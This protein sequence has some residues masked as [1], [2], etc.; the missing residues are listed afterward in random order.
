MGVAGRRGVL[1]GLIMLLGLALRLIY[2]NELVRSPDFQYPDVD[3]GY[4]DYWAR[5]LASADWSL[6]PQLADPQIQSRPFFRPPGYPYFIAVIYKLFPHYSHLAVCVLQMALGL[7][8][9]LLAFIL[10]RKCFN[11]SVGLVFAALMSFY[12]TFIFYEGELQTPVLHISL[13]FGLLISLASWWERRR[14]LEALAAGMLAG[15]AAL[16]IPGMLLLLPV[17]VVWM[18]RHSRERVRWRAWVAGVV[19][20]VLGAA[21]MIAPATI[22]N[23]RQ[24]DDLVLI[25]SNGGINLFI[26]NNPTADGYCSPYIGNLGFFGT[27][28]DYP[29]IVRQL[30]R[31]LG[32][33]VKYSEASR[34]FTQEALRYIRDQPAQVAG[35]TLKKALLFWGPMEVGHNKEDH[36]IRVFS[37][38]LSHLP[39]NFALVLTLFVLGLI[40]WV[41]TR[42][43]EAT[44]DGSERK[45]SALVALSLGFTIVY[46]LSYLPFFIAARYRVPI[47]PLL[48]LPGAAGLCR[49]G[50]LVGRKRWGAVGATIAG[51]VALYVLFSINW[52]NYQPKLHRWHFDRGVVFMRQGNADAAIREYSAAIDAKPDYEFAR[53][54]LAT[55]L[56]GKGDIQGAMVQYKTILTAGPNPQAYHNLG[57]ILLR[58]G[59]LEEAIECFRRATKLQPTMEM[60]RCSLGEALRMT[61]RSV[62]AEQEFSRA[63]RDNP[64]AVQARTCLGNLYASSGKLNEAIACYR[65]VV[66]INPNMAPAHFNLGILL[67]RGNQNAEADQQIREALRQ[68]PGLAN[69]MKQK[70]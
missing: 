33:A 61:G 14:F 64:T 58:S 32:H 36:Y 19:G 57:M 10:G 39:G 41:G 48:L 47:I 16:L 29:G 52:A 62:E 66:A 45:T 11:R 5:G 68:D 59:K 35:L 22:R 63:I 37:P 53:A 55:L 12:W 31:R 67:K 28:F 24:A 8:N 23:A 43:E 15:L 44:V 38:L 51:G 70:R 54:N 13:L 18:A 50:E 46:F 65:E 42:S 21:L 25:S 26:G 40:L 69:R 1:L 9:C 2:L 49:F 27:C 60:L 7:L 17:V 6:P 4:H 30:E 3:A 34:W 20:V 56:E